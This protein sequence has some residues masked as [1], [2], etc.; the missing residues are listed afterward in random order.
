MN[1]DSLSSNRAAEGVMTKRTVRSLVACVGIAIASAAS[2]IVHAGP[3]GSGW[4][5]DTPA[6]VNNLRDRGEAFTAIAHWLRDANGRVSGFWF[7]DGTVVDASATSANAAV[8]RMRPGDRVHL[9]Y[10]PAATLAIE[11]L[12]RGARVDV[13]PL[14][15]ARGGGPNSTGGSA[16][17]V[18]AVRGLAMRTEAA[19]LRQI[20]FDVGG[21]PRALLLAS[22]VQVILAPRVADV[23]RAIPIGTPLVVH[24]YSAP[25]NAESIV[26]SRIERAD[27]QV[28]MDLAR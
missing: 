10:G 6:A 18:P 16:P 5:N 26:A 8:E 22:G 13:G 12:D 21:R 7:S 17:A 11:D 20:G 15:L 28:V 27:G 1:A 9:R 3:L 25:R 23:A 14:T 19:P 4:T 2:S 24:G